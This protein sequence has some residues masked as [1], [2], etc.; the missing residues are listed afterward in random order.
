MQQISELVHLWVPRSRDCTVTLLEFKLKP[1]KCKHKLAIRVYKTKWKDLFPRLA[2]SL[3]RQF[4][5]ELW[6]RHQRHSEHT[7]QYGFTS[8]M[9]CYEEKP[10]CLLCSKVLSAESMK[11]NKLKRHFETPHKEHVGKPRAFFENKFADRTNS[12]C[13]ISKRLWLLVNGPWKLLLRWAISL[14]GIWSHIALLRL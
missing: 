5:E 6:H 8:V 4:Q 3:Q 7:I 9:E 12:K 11:P 10:K 2:L 13:S 1:V 14:L